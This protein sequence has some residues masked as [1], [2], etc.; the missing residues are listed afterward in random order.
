[1]SWSVL[2]SFGEP[3]RYRSGLLSVTRGFNVTS[4]SGYLQIT[5]CTNQAAFGGD[6]RPSRATKGLSQQRLALGE[7][8]L[9]VVLE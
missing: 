9:C 5:H 4:N 2:S 8:L 3:S 6:W 7:R 1:M